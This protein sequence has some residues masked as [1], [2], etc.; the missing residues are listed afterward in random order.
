MEAQFALSDLIRIIR[1]CAGEDDT[2][3]LTGE[4]GDVTFVDLG[5]DS[6]A[7]LEA[8]GAVTRQYGVELAEDDVAGASTP[9][10]FVA[11]VNRKQ[12]GVRS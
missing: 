10:E 5:Y 7:I 12:V 3:D 4:I 8:A 1:E 2:V 6:L 9:A 11:V